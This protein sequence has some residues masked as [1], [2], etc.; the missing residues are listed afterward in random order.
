MVASPKDVISGGP[1]PRFLTALYRGPPRWKTASASRYDADVRNRRPP[2]PTHPSRPWLWFGIV[3]A[4]GS[5]VW[6]GW[7]AFFAPLA[8]AARNGSG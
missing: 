2:R 6:L 5:V 4:W 8:E 3:A 1:S 7:W